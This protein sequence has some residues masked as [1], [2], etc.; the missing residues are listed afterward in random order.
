MSK[1]IK[2]IVVMSCA[3]SL[4]GS[5]L[6]E[7]LHWASVDMESIFQGY[8]KTV[9]ADEIIKKQT[10]IYREYAINLEKERGSLQDTAAAQSLDFVDFQTQII[11]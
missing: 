6:A 5:L 3:L 8:Y 4:T 2:K 1:F 10:E 7:E 9:K 11:D